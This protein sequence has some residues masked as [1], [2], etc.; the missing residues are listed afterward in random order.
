MK[1]KLVSYHPKKFVAAFWVFVF[2]FSVVHKV[3]ISIWLNLQ[4]LIGRGAI[5]QIGAVFQDPAEQ[6]PRG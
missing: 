4:T 2:F 6:N 3:S 5:Q 1:L